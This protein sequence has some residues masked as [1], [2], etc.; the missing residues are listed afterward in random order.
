VRL[1]LFLVPISLLA[2]SLPFPGPGGVAAPAGPAI[3]TRKVCFAQASSPSAA[4]DMSGADLIVAA[5]A[6]VNGGGTLTLTDSRGSNDSKYA[7]NM[8]GPA[9][10]T[11]PGISWTWAQNASVGAGQTFSISVGGGQ[12][13][14]ACIYGISLMNTSSPF[15]T[16]GTE[17]Q[18]SSG[19][20][21]PGAVTP[22]S[23]Y[24]AILAGI[25]YDNG[26][27]N[28]VSIDSAFSAPDCIDFATGVNYGMCLSAKIQSGSAAAHPTYSHT[29]G[30]LTAANTVF[31]GQ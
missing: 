29:P 20:V 21:Q 1:A 8:T 4:V 3:G 16:R 5:I 2:Q 27:G 18:A 19:T 23:G 30:T 7:S 17:A 10:Q 25:A 6:S 9:T 22:G 28:A 14:A 31:Q 24:Q 12:Q 15:E 26:T 13:V 11:S